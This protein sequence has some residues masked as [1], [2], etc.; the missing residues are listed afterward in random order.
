MSATLVRNDQ[1]WAEPPAIDEFTVR[2]VPDSAAEV[3][4]LK[5]GEVDLVELIPFA[6][7]EEIGNTPA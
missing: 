3:Q 6:Q 1:Y 5:A 4:A 2:I 7:V